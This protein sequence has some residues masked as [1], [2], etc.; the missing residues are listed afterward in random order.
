VVAERLAVRRKSPAKRLSPA[1]LAALEDYAWPGNVRE[2][3]NAVE[4]A[5]A[6]AGEE[7]VVEPGHLPVHLRAQMVRQG[8]TE[9]DAAPRGADLPVLDPATFP[10]LKDYR[11]RALAAL[12]RGYLE[13]LLALAGDDISRACT[14]SGLSRA[15]L[16]A[17]LKSRG[18]GR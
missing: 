15:R 3:L 13:K 16:Y 1:L 6:A 18:L 14:L 11:N 2:L 5:M 9:P 4:N 8:L 10:R 7:K 17:L 12:E